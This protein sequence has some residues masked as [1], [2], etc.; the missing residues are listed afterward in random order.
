MSYAASID[1]PKAFSISANRSERTVEISHAGLNAR[2]EPLG[3]RRFGAVWMRK[4]P[5]SRRQTH[6]SLRKYA[7]THLVSPVEAAPLITLPVNAWAP[8]RAGVEPVS[9]IGRALLG[10]IFYAGSG[11]GQECCNEVAAHHARKP[12]LAPTWRATGVK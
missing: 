6:I 9:G 12:T 11:D 8:Q 2:G 4:I 7:R 5:A 3:V 10:F 1:R